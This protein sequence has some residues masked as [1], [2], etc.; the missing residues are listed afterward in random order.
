MTTTGVAVTDG[1]TP[2]QLTTVFSSSLF[3]NGVTT[4]GD[5][6][7][8]VS[9]GD[10]GGAVQGGMPQLVE[11]VDGTPVPYPDSGWSSWRQGEA[12]EG[13]FVGLNST[14]VGPDGTLWAVDRGTV[15]IGQP[16]TPGAPRLIGFDL[17]TDTMTRTYDLDSATMPWSFVDDVRFHG[18]LAYLTDC[19]APA[20]IVLDLVSGDTRRVLEGHPSVVAQQPLRAEHRNLV[21]LDGAPVNIHVDQLEVSPDGAWLYFQPCCGRM[22]RIP[23]AVLDDPASGPQALADAVESFA[24]TASTGGTAIGADGT[25]YVSQVDDSR[26]ITVSPEGEIDVLV[27]DVR[28]A[29]VDAMWIDDG[30]QLLMPAAQL[31]RTAD[32]NW[33]IDVA[34]APFTV[35]A[36]PTGTTPSRS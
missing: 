18:D 34:A 28:L 15:A 27:Q 7:F 21:D 6:M 9:Q 33:G 22:S 35:Y 4:A 14:R 36:Y 16:R 26:I 23:T 19:G 25:L 3:I 8:G 10:A 30:G 24:A 5:R 20:I 17:D 11:I 12:V 32:L 1:A 29:W 13:R 31:N 2:D